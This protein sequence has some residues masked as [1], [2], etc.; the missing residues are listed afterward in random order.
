M[1]ENHKELFGKFD[2][3]ENEFKFIKDIIGTNQLTDRATLVHSAV[4]TMFLSKQI[5]QSIQQLIK[6]NENLAK[7]TN[8]QSGIMILLTLAIAI[9]TYILVIRG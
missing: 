4:A 6:S 7:A 3:D 1:I 8:I 2:T 5:E 9:M